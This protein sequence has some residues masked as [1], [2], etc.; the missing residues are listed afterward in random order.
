MRRVLIGFGALVVAG[1]S[2]GASQGGA[3]EAAGG[4]VIID[5]QDARVSTSAGEEGGVVVLFPRVMGIPGDEP[6]TLQQHMVEVAQR[7]FPDRPIDVRPD[8]ERV[9]PRRGCRGVSLGALL[10]VQNG[11]CATVGIIGGP[12]PTD[13]RLTRWSGRL[14]LRTQTIPF[15]E[16]PESY[17]TLQDASPCELLTEHLP[18]EDSAVEEALRRAAGY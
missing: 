11:Q 17:V 18:V 5:E 16:P 3:V 8:P 6:A 12:G 13:L 4:E 10:V 7:V 1:C 15:R 14:I 2:G 9:C